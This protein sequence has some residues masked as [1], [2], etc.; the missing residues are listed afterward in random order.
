MKM[1]RA[2]ASRR[3]PV[4]FLA[5]TSGA[6]VASVAMGA[7]SLS[8]DELA[9]PHPVLAQ[10]D[11][12][13]VDHALRVGASGVDAGRLSDLRDGLGLVDVPVER[14]HGLHLL[15]ERSDGG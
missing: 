6:P 10:V 5:K 11:D 14:E 9:G 13:P 8:C 15:D 4:A 2:D 12:G 3:S 7:S 1:S